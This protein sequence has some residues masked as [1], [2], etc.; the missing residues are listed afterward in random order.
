MSEKSR[1]QLYYESFKYIPY[2]PIEDLLFFCEKHEQ[3]YIYGVSNNASSIL[4]YLKV[5]S[6]DVKAYVVSDDRIGNYSELMADGIPILSLSQVSDRTR[7]GFILCL[8]EI[9][10]NDAINNLKN[11][12]FLDFYVMRE[13]DKYVMCEKLQKHSL[14]SLFFAFSIVDH[15][16][17]GCRRCC[18]FSQ[19]SEVNFMDIGVFKQDLLKFRELTG[20]CFT[21][22][23]S[24]SGGEALLHPIITEFASLLRE[25][26]PLASL[27]LCTNGIK[28]LSM[29]DSFWNV[30]SEC[31]FTIVL[32][33][34]PINLDF[35]AIMEKTRHFNVP[36]YAASNL[37][38]G[39][40]KPEEKFSSKYPFD[41]CGKQPRGNFMGCYAFNAAIIMKNGKLFTCSTI[42][43]M[44]IFNQ[45]FGMNLEV[46]S[47][48]FLD[49]HQAKDFDEV[50]NFLKKP[51]A[52]CKYCD[53]KHRRT[54]G[55]W[56]LSEKC[57]EEYVD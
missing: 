20:G 12:G 44:H 25:V 42:A 48:D 51:P 2:K 1:I 7:T 41:L 49:I 19:L 43:N 54:D 39:E 21:G 33:T 15:C 22:D 23:I 37:T 3:L 34:Y 30:L 13:Y 17:L 28:L 9:Y 31:S 18:T 11:Y 24:I 38:D 4:E 10:Y 16:N 27:S 35:S 47:E 55:L 40:S 53:V 46:G 57:I 26:F 5:I 50:A 45:Y 6:V 14:D 32:T 56:A 52:F 8:P 29:D 36:I